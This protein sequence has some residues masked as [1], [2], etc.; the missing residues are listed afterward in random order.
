MNNAILRLFSSSVILWLLAACMNAQGHDSPNEITQTP[1]QM[2]GIYYAYPQ[3]D[4]LQTPAPQGYVPFYVSHYGRHGSRW[5][6]ADEHYL[7]VIRVFDSFH[8]QS[9]LTTLGEDAR[10]R[11]HF[12]WENAQGREGELSP[13]GE[14]QH[15]SIAKRLYQNYPQIFP[16]GARISARSSTSVRCVMS[17]AAFSEQLKELDPTLQITREASQKYMDYI[18]YT[19]PELQNLGPEMVES[20][21]DIQSFQEANIHPERLMSTL[22]KHPEQVENA[23]QLMIWMFAVAGM[24]QD[25]ELP[26]TL[27]DLYEKDEMFAIW[28][29]SN[30]RMY[31]ANAAAPVNRGIAPRSATSLLKNIIESTDRA[32][33]EQTPSATLRFGHDTNLIRLLALMQ[34]EGCANEETDISRFYQAWQ[35]YHVAPMGGNLQ[36]I[37]FKNKD[38]KV[39][40]KF[41]HNENE[42][43]LPINSLTGVYYEWEK[44]KEFL[45]T[46]LL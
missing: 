23:Q 6:N 43:E 24:V 33:Q 39:L 25:V 11:L 26:V 42:V 21:N 44:V 29:L 35:D 12:I 32:I 37:F 7:R 27:Y 18:A 5:M 17:M 40:V 46:K 15:K 13:L 8:Q 30:S 2:A 45:S 1:Q 22:F 4:G 38:G 34:V 10:K 20:R 31:V 16:Q 36:M 19:S 3:P 41:L 14:R 9:G 28:Q